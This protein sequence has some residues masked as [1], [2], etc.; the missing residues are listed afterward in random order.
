ML[1]YSGNDCR[2]GQY[3]LKWRTYHS[4]IIINDHLYSWGGDQDNLPHVHD[5]DKKRK[6]TSSVDI[7][8]LPTFEWKNMSTSGTPPAGVMFYASTNLRNNVYYFCGRCDYD[9]C[10]HNNLFELNCMTNNWTEIICSTPDTLPIRKYG[11]GMISFSN[12]TEDTLLVVGG[13]GLKPA[14]TPTHSRYVTRPAYPNE[15]Y[16]NETHMMCI[17][18]APGIT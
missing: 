11:C 18:S 2:S 4:T 16:T 1:L 17:S 8:T 7:F 5:N 13:A 14:T 3:Q 6:I 15:C 10:Y 12:N 9:E